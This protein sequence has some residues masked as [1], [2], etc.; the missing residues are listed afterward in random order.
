MFTGGLPPVVLALNV[1]GTPLPSGDVVVTFAGQVSTNVGGVGAD[2]MVATTVT[3]AN[4]PFVLLTR[5]VASCWPTVN[6]AVW[7][8][9]VSV[10]EFVPLLGDTLSQFALDCATVHLSAPVPALLTCTVLE[11]ALVPAVAVVVTDSGLTESTAC[12]ST[13]K[14]SSTAANTSSGN[15]RR[16]IKRARVRM[17]ILKVI[18]ESGKAEFGTSS[19]TRQWTSRRPV[20][21]RIGHGGA[22]IVIV[23]LDL[24]SVQL[25]KAPGAG[26]SLVTGRR[27]NVGTEGGPAAPQRL[28]STGEF[29]VTAPTAHSAEGAGRHRIAQTNYRHPAGSPATASSSSAHSNATIRHRS[30]SRSDCARTRL[31]WCWSDRAPPACSCSARP[32]LG[33]KRWSRFWS[34]R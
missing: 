25:P 26:L 32:R 14:G 27:I 11:G 18:V 13:G 5:N 7:K 2:V 19:V 30:E 33:R 20:A 34:R 16:D 31:P 3:V 1:T 9:I 10:P 6:A 29:H 17:G 4:V 21:D 15:P 23:L 28:R 8:V 22:P 12:A 24:V